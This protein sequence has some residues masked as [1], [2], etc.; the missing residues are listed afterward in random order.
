MKIGGTLFFLD[1]GM[2]QQCKLPQKVLEP[3]ND[4][5]NIYGPNN[6]E[7]F[8]LSIKSV[9]NSV[10]LF[11]SRFQGNICLTGC[12][13]NSCAWMKSEST[14]AEKETGFTKKNS[15]LSRRTMMEK[16]RKAKQEW[17]QNMQKSQKALEEYHRQVRQ[18]MPYKNS[19]K[20]DDF[21]FFLDYPKHNETILFKSKS[22]SK[23]IYLDDRAD[24]SVA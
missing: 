18:I 9:Q 11:W 6:I 17:C 15:K 19:L 23:R 4:F 1:T 12:I 8:C 16:V 24:F 7:P 3:L 13:V 22:K 2:I 14:P 20:E 21:C 5:K 10:E